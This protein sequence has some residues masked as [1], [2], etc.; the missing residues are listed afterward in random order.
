MKKIICKLIVLGFRTAFWFRYRIKVKG[1]DK[2]NKRSLPKKGGVLFLPN[3]PTVFL[4]PTMVAITAWNKFPIRPL[5]TDEFY[6]MPGV[7][8]LMSFINALPIPNF[9][10][11]SN[12]LKKKK[13]EDVIHLVVDDLEN[14]D[15]FLLYPAGRTKQTG[16][17][18]VGGTSATHRIIQGAPDANIVLVRTKGLWGSSFSRAIVGEAPSLSKTLLDN[19]L[20]TLKNLIFFNPRRE[21]TIEFEL[22]PKDFPYSSTKR[23]MNKWLE[24]WFNRPDGLTK[25][26]G[27]HPGDSLVLVSYSRWSHQ[28]PVPFAGKSSDDDLVDMSKVSIDTKNKIIDEIAKISEVPKDDIKVEDSFNSDL[29][30]DSLD[31]SEVA[32]Y[33]QHN[34]SVKSVP[35][36]ELT[37]IKKALGI[38]SKQ[39]ECKPV[40]PRKAKV[41]FEAWTKPSPRIR[42]SLADGATIPEV[43][44][45]NSARMGNLS[46]CGDEIAGVL[47]YKDLRLRII[48]LA[49]YIRR[50]PG[51]Y[52]GILL[53][54]SVAAYAV[55][56]GC[57]L[58]GKVPMLINWTM[59]SRHL[60]AVKMLSNVEVI[61]SSWAFIDRLDDV[62]LTPIENELVMLEDVRREFKIKDKLKA[63][64]RSKKST[65]SI[66]NTFGIDTLTKDDQA[67][68]LFTSGTESLPKGVP[69]THNNVLSN[70]RQAFKSIDLYSDDIMFGILPP[71]H[72][73]GFTIS[74]FLGL[75]SGIKT[76]YS[77]DPTDGSKLAE[78]VKNWSVTIMCGAPTFLKSMLRSGS[79]EHFKTLRL[80]VTGA[81]K[82]PPELFQ[83]AA[84]MKCEHS[85][86]EGYGI[87]ECAPVLTIN[88]PGM[89]PGGVGQ[90]LDG[91]DLMVV[92]P[93]TLEPLG[94]MQRGLVLAKGDN[95]FDGYINADVSSPFV[96][97]DGDKWFKTG[98]LGH[99]DDHN[100]LIISGRQKRF[101]KMGGEMIS[102]TAI[103][104]ALLQQAEKRGWKVAE[105]G[106]T[107]AICAKEEA[108]TKTKISLFTIFDTNVGEVNNAL[109]DAGFSNLVRVSSVKKLEAIPIMGSGK[110]FY[111]E[112]ENAYMNV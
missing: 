61:L 14:G 25:Q 42:K 31:V 55:I 82:A 43:F 78:I 77:A 52:V 84:Q 95:I 69:L 23:E 2:L 96:T 40:V 58:A 47:S 12:S 59:G 37:T 81:E 103:E 39:I 70:L 93:D 33:I 105:D 3:H 111:R 62:N 92:N 79:S 10:V 72:A 94:D 30:M 110:V 4:D 34:F 16:K 87:T 67:V 29:G 11:T 88:R 28:V 57:Q 107:L 90:P 112:L 109:R 45:N 100:R 83:I 60:E 63:F 85:I 48:L 68:L 49:E 7:H 8:W 86:Y 54:S 56:L 50:L 75:L 102:L 27:S 101:V 19:L 20:H 13:S 35:V 18:V 97:I 65:S 41:D 108:G 74:G 106:P 24:D 46:A 6:Y 80:C 91:V 32:S 89:H 26:E 73:F 38:A 1:L 5:I 36:T 71:F 51:K 99:L 53:P 15:N 76:V 9:D 66:L 64:I 17:E 22:A 21:V 104:E 98:D 44:L